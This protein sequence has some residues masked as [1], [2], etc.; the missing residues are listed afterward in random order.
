MVTFWHAMLAASRKLRIA[1]TAL[2]TLIRY[3]KF[4]LLMLEDITV[5]AGQ[6]TNTLVS[7]RPIDL[8]IKYRCFVFVC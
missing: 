7:L 2:K 6:L 1:C 8:D 3:R 4:K 5:A